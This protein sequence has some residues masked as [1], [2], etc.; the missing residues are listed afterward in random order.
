MAIFLTLCSENEEL[1]SM[2]LLAYFFLP[3]TPKIKKALGTT[4]EMKGKTMKL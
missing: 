4:P 3:V 1:Q 2:R